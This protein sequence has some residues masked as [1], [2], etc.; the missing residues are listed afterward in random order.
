MCVPFA[1]R[2]LRFAAMAATG[3]PQSAPYT[4]P[5]C[6]G[7]GV[8]LRRIGIVCAALALVL[9]GCDK[10]SSSENEIRLDMPRPNAPAEL[11][12]APSYAPVP[13][14]V[15]Q[16]KSANALV[17]FRHNLTLTMPRDGVAARFQAARDAC[18]KDK[19][20]SCVLTS[21]S[22]T[23][24]D[25][26]SAQLSVALPHDKVALFEKRLMKPLPQDG[27]GKVAVT[28]RS[29]S[30]ENETQTAAD[31][32]REL[33]QAKTYRDQLEELAKRPNLTV[34]EVIKIHSELKEAQDAVDSAEAAKRA[35]DSNIVLETMNISLNEEALPP[36]ETSAFAD[37][38]KNAGSV[39]ASS[40]ATM[41]L[42]VVNAVPWIP[43]ILLLAL[44]VARVTGRI[45]IRRSNP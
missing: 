13:D 33:A 27:N 29:T 41:L 9:A 24:S 8:L 21:A 26:V 1:G 6:Q 45:R 39:L 5:A 43:V 10:P 18:L 19:T 22:F 32:D 4:F 42:H 36:V 34:D 28:S 35:S 3:P 2:R 40:T 44:L 25:T 37:F 16:T 38:W 11:M 30:T 14:I 20:L 12:A 17:S 31:V 7:E 15:I 23:A